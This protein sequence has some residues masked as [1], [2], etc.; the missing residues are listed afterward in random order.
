MIDELF[1]PPEQEE[2][3]G[4]DCADCV[5]EDPTEGISTSDEFKDPEALEECPVW[6]PQAA[7]W[8]EGPVLFS[9]PGTFTDRYQ[10]VE[11][12]R[13]YVGPGEQGVVSRLETSLIHFDDNFDPLIVD[14]GITPYAYEIAEGFNF[15]SVFLFHLRLDTW[16]R[17]NAL[18]GAPAVFFAADN[19][20]GVPYPYLG[21]WPDAR[22]DYARRD[23]HVSLVVPE[24]HVLRLFVQVRIV[25]RPVFPGNVYGRLAGITQT[26]RHS[27]DAVI[28]A[29]KWPRG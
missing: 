28:E 29:R 24:S 26:Y 3:F 10:C 15:P 22:Y 20:P 13:F 18:P 6:T 9:A 5:L 27:R 7:K 17:S 19:L 14:G 2:P 8:Q 25:P 4:K 11:L 16:R 1:K 23:N 12:S 21:S